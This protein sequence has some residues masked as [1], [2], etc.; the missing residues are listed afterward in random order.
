MSDYKKGERR[1]DYFSQKLGAG[2]K[3]EMCCY[4]IFLESFLDIP[5]MM[6]SFRQIKKEIYLVKSRYHHLNR[7][8]WKFCQETYLCHFAF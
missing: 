4:L 6:T 1:I 8:H 3:K 7:F 2:K 5:K